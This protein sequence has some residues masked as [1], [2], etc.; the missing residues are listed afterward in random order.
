M[1]DAHEADIAE[2]IGGS[3]HKGSGNQ[4]H[5]QMDASNGE[6]LTPFPIAGDGKSTLGDSL[7][8]TRKMW[9]KAVDQTFGKIPAIFS[10]RYADQSLRTVDIDLVTLQVAHFVEILEAAR[11]WRTQEDAGRYFCP[12][13]EEVESQ[14]GGGFDQCCDRPDLHVPLPEGEGTERLSRLLGDRLKGLCT[15]PFE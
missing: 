9:Q 15:E 2:W 7:T 3:V 6:Y 10:R 11:K 14:S 5:R 4:W 1:G 13:S 12:T 8:I